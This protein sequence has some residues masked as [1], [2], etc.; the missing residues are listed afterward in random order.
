[1]DQIHRLGQIGFTE[2][3][4]KVYLALLREYP[5]TGYQLSKSSGVPVI[6]SYSIH[7]TKLY[8]FE[9]EGERLSLKGDLSCDNGSCT[10]VLESEEV[11]NVGNVPGLIVLYGR[12][13]TVGRLP[14]RIQQAKYPFA[15]LLQT[16]G[17]IDYSYNFV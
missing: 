12:D 11:P 4:A 1:M 16:G 3:E 6:T 17:G 5:A 9:P 10:S 8:E 7:Y 15:G 14:A 2:Y 13:E